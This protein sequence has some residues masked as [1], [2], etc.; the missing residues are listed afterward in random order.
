[1]IRNPHPEDVFVFGPNDWCYREEWEYCMGDDY[2]T[3]FTE[4]P[5]WAHF[6]ENEA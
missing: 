4:T 1:M 3:L 6:M 5:E 2:T